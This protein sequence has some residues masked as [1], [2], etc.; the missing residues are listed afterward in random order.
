MPKITHQVLEEVL[1]A[2]GVYSV[3]GQSPE[4]GEGDLSELTSSARGDPSTKAERGTPP[5]C[6]AGRAPCLV[7]ADTQEAEP[8]G[9]PPG[10]GCHMQCLGFPSRNPRWCDSLLSSDA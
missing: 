8:A 2:G 9:G 6:M 3:F 4:W 5:S 1:E 7:R 10:K